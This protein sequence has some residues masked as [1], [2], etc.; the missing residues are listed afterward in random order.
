MLHWNRQEKDDGQ[1]KLRLAALQLPSLCD[2]PSGVLGDQRG[3]LD[4][5]AAKGIPQ[6]GA[7]VA[8]FWTC[9]LMHGRLWVA[10]L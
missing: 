1:R 8:R 9:V 7:L 5:K 10:T 4:L 6:C 2:A 3:I